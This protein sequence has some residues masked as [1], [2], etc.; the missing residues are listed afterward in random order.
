MKTTRPSTPNELALRTLVAST[1]PVRSRERRPERSGQNTFV[2]GVALL[3]TFVAVNEVAAEGPA[4]ERAAGAV[5]AAI[6]A[7]AAAVW[8]RRL[9]TIGRGALAIAVGSVATAVVIGMRAYVIGKSGLS[10]VDA[11]ALP[12]LVAELA[13][14]VVGTRQVLR[15]VPGWRRVLAVPAGLAIVYYL[16]WPVA[17]GLMLTHAPAIELGSRTPADLG[18]AY[19]EVVV[20]TRDGVALA[21]WYLPSDHGAAI[22]VL[23][24]AG[25]TRTSA[26]D[27]AAF[28]HEQGYG[29]LLIDSRGFGESGGT[30]MIGG[31]FGDLDVDAAVTF[32][33]N[34]PDVDPSRI[35][36]FGLSMGG[37]EA[38]A[39]A[40]GD[41]RI[42][43]V[44]AE[45]AGAIRSTAD[46]RSIPGFSRYLGI[47]HYWVQTV[48]ADLFTDAGPPIALE[49]SMEGIAPRP[50]LLISAERELAFTERY[51]AAAPGSTELW[52]L[53][54]AP[55]IGG[56]STHPAEYR[57]RVLS[58][59]DDAIGDA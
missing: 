10:A 59:F 52:K 58:F 42:A 21:G 29:T 45:G 47:P 19:E 24:G 40:G 30:A 56:L 46:T 36:V 13:L 28:L 9:G 43:V 27:H 41:E 3:A 23:H 44:V 12:A 51:Q 57:S 34:R 14:L 54:D 39:A 2:V 16:V 49:E 17:I 33:A 15:P 25:S 32:L 37:E 4:L 6:G 7:A 26:L 48:V 38:I 50:V 20:P 53:A 5:S 35:G 8:F 1:E 22:V 18:L 31:W 11:V 55:H